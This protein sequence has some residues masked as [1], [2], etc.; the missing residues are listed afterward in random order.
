MANDPYD[1]ASR[2][3]HS[4]KLQ[5]F[6]AKEPISRWANI[7]RLAEES[8]EFVDRTDAM[9]V[10]KPLF[11]PQR[12]TMEEF[13]ARHGLTLETSDLAK[14]F[15]DHFADIDER[16]EIALGHDAMSRAFA[17]LTLAVGL[18]VTGSSFTNVRKRRPRRTAE[19]V[20]LFYGEADGIEFEPEDTPGRL[21]EQPGVD[22]RPR[23]PSILESSISAA[24]GG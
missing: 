3:D 13:M 20:K 7:Y 12:L 19:P 5:C 17:F 16:P 18:R 24:R 1:H 15:F 21:A 4:E 14:Q 8:G 22:A 23:G 10:G 9:Q 11:V 2:G 6:F